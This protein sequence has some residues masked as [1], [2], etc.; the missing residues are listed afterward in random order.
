MSARV[1][2]VMPTETYRAA[3]FV[4]AAGRLGVELSIA[5]EE[6][7]PL[8]PP[9]RQTQINCADPVSSAEQIAELATTTTIDAIIAADDAG[10][11]VAARA[12]QLM[13]LPS[14]PVA[15]V[16][17]TL[18]KH[19]MRN[20]LSIG[21]VPQPTFRIAANV[22]D[23][24]AAAADIGYPV[25]SKPRTRSAS[26]GV[27]RS[28]E[29]D[30]LADAFQVAAT[31]QYEDDHSSS[32]LVEGFI[33]GPE[34]SVE[35]I[36]W[37]GRLEIAAVFDKPDQ[38]D[39]PTFEETIFVTPSSLDAPTMKA[40]E[41]TVQAAVAALGLTNGPI[42]AELRVPDG[43]PTVIEVA[44][45]TIGG[46]CGRSLTFGLMGESLEMLV[47]RQALGMP[48]VGNSRIPGGTGVMMIPALT[49][50]KITAISGLDA[51]RTVTGITDIEMTAPIGAGVMPAPDGDRYLGFIFATGPDRG[52]VLTSLRSAYSKIE[53]TIV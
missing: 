3:D 20:L 1:V 35:G 6:T 4:N 11:E 8:I 51:A 50:G 45:R 44:G 40:V 14:S 26:L 9:D 25:V 31:H 19:T 29:P 36:I 23:A 13:G 41:H 43:R 2:V 27:L 30:D 5:S 17:A 28:D 47:L 39:G 18:D 49:T 22:A 7:L 38:P 16:Q 21:E 32:I 33:P 42:H 34:V 10:V 37:E 48:K 53:I 24:L 15:A 12:A 52:S 46:I